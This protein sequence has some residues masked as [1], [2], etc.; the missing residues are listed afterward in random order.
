MI[1]SNAFVRFCSQKSL[2]KG[3][4]KGLANCRKILHH[5][6]PFPTVLYELH[7]LV[8]CFPKTWQ[9]YYDRCWWFYF[10]L[11]II[12]THC[13]SIPGLLEGTRRHD[14]YVGMFITSHNGSTDLDLTFN[15]NRCIFGLN[16]VSIKSSQ[17]RN[18]QM[19]LVGT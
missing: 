14:K 12:L 11:Y 1:L 5:L 6:I 19:D 17:K 3:K 15:R 18:H 8:S 7:H 10:A 2:S 13:S 16:P 4:G 9:P